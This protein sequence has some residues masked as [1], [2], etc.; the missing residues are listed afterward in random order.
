MLLGI[1]RFTSIP[2]NIH[3][4]LAMFAHAYLTV[5]RVQR[6]EASPTDSIETA[7]ELLPLTVPEVRHVLWQIVWPHAPPLWFVLAWSRWRRRHQ[8]RAKRVHTKHRWDISQGRTTTQVE[9][10]RLPRSKGHS[11]KRKGTFRP[12]LLTMIQYSADD[13]YLLIDQT[14]VQPFHVADGSEWQVILEKVPS[15]HFT[16]KQGHFTARKEQV[17]GK[18]SYWY[19]Y[20]RYHNKQSKRYI[21]TTAKLSPDALE[22]AAAALE[23]KIA[24]IS[25]RG[26]EQETL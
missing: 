11:Q 25:A 23:A 18:R 13:E 12:R 26:G 16:G 19:A 1:V 15:F 2:N 22:Q 10:E 5:M 4:T 20:R 9:C 21:G 7:E 24:Q 14:G 8:A 6:R 17:Q 3:I